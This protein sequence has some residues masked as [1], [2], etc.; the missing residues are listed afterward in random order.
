MIIDIESQHNH[1]VIDKLWLTVFEQ[2][3]KDVQEVPEQELYRLI[4]KLGRELL[5]ETKLVNDH[6]M[7][8]S[9]G[10]PQFILYFLV[11][12]VRDRFR[13]VRYFEL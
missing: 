9:K 12:V 10:A 8:S 13:I 2:V 1:N 11:E 4:L 7:I 3:V 6:A 5:I